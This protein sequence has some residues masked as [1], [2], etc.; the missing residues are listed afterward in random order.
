M[1]Y[2]QIDN[3]YKKNLKSKD[4]QYNGQRQMTNNDLQNTTQKTKDRATRTPLKTGCEHMCPGRVSSSCSTS[5]T[6]GVTLDTNPVTSHD[7][8]TQNIWKTF[9]VTTLT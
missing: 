2:S 3:V 1:R 8:G 9:E 6:R 4:R 7:W 5:G